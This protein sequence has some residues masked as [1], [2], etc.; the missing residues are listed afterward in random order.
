MPTAQGSE[1][2]SEESG[3]QE[4]GGGWKPG[5]TPK[6][7]TL[8]A[9]RDV[10]GGRCARREF[11]ARYWFCKNALEQ[12]IAEDRVIL[13]A[14]GDISLPEWSGKIQSP[15]PKQ[16]KGDA[17][18]LAEALQ[19]ETGA[20]KLGE[21]IMLPDGGRYVAI[22]HH[23]P[24]DTIYQLVKSRHPDMDDIGGRIARHAKH[25]WAVTPDQM[26]LTEPRKAVT[27]MNRELLAKA[28]L[29]PKARYIHCPNAVLAV[30]AEGIQVLP[31]DPVLYR[32]TRCLA[33]EYEPQAPVSGAMDYLRDLCSGAGRSTEEVEREVQRLMHLAAH[34]IRPDHGPQLSHILYGPAD[35]GKSSFLRFMRFLMGEDNVSG[36]KLT[37]LQ[38]DRFSLAQVGDALANFGA[39]EDRGADLRYVRKWREV[40]G[41]DKVYVRG[42]YQQ[43]E[44]KSIN[45]T[46]VFSTN[47]MPRF[48]SDRQEVRRVQI[49]TFHRR[50]KH[51]DFEAR[52]LLTDEMARGMLKLAVDALWVQL[53]QH[54]IPDGVQ[55]TEEETIAQ[56]ADHGDDDLSEAIRETLEPHPD[57]RMT[58]HEIQDVVEPE[59]ARTMSERDY[60]PKLGRNALG[61]HPAIARASFRAK[62]GRHYRLR[63]V[64]ATDRT[65]QDT[66]TND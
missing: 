18:V 14:N 31:A 65:H 61:K 21:R 45:A 64:D 35:S 54:G 53:Q 6:S 59:L 15:Q 46:L 26:N 12:L 52:E 7:D 13:W 39:D 50:Y 9:L 28:K 62:T 58:F 40:V 5:P 29:D 17:A 44:S 4:D 25:A 66:L 2:P 51:T 63:P 48:G 33:T 3:P 43:G 22:N 49:V 38:H 36:V 19:A 41:E 1:V 23:K 27:M 11:E 16:V 10:Y 60:R 30:T 8:A 20:V 34:C 37:D 32:N 55:Y 56:A 24:E 47:T 42:L 57:G